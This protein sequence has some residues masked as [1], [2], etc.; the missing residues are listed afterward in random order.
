M[1][2]VAAVKTIKKANNTDHIL[3]RDQVDA[4][5]DGKSEPKAAVILDDDRVKDVK[6]LINDMTRSEASKR[7]TA[8]QV[9]QTLVDIYHEVMSILNL[10]ISAWAYL[11]TCSLFIYYRAISL[12]AVWLHRREHPLRNNDRS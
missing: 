3:G 4:A 8:G 5:R 12:H 2:F 9:L 10:V 11:C 6:S 7:P 1:Y